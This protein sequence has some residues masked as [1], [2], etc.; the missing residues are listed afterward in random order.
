MLERLDETP[1]TDSGV[2]HLEHLTGLRTVS[3]S[4]TGIG[5]EAAQHLARMPNLRNVDLSYTKVTD[6][7]IGR[8]AL[9]RRV[10]INAFF[11]ASAM[12]DC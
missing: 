3:F 5:D 6:D 4:H 11:D 8:L 10:V 9:P 2:K 1:M 7:G 12:S